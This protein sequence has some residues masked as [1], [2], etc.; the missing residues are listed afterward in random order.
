MA[1]SSPKDDDDAIT[2]INVTPLV[3]VSLVLVII[4]MA[5]APFGLQAGI[6]VL[7]SKAKA[8][9]GKVQAS[10]NVNVRLTKDGKLTVNGKKTTFAKLWRVIAKSL[11]KS[12]DKMVILTADAENRVGD[13]VTVLDTARQAGAKKLAIVKSEG[14]KG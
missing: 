11:G 1:G 12:K 7:Q 4:F 8:S 13:V 3:D 9:V 10:Q 2:E 6:Q 5:I 14:T